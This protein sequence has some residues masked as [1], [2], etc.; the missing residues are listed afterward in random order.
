MQK[1]RKEIL[2]PPDG[3]GEVSILILS[4]IPMLGRPSTLGDVQ[5]VFAMISLLPGKNKN[6][7]LF[8]NT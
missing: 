2:R 1:T 6:E 7:L 5:L 8:P 3:V 4:S